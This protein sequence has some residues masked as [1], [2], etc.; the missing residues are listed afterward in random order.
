MFVTRE[1]LIKRLAEKSG[2][3][4]KD[5]KEVFNA[6]DDVV[7]EVFDEVTDDEELLLQL[8]EGIRIG[9]KVVPERARKNPRDQSDII[10]PAQVK[11]FTKFSRCFKEKI[12]VQYEDRKDG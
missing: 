11:P 6:L 8:V 4:M 1:Q 12:Q 2:Y 9:C 5:I 7:V 3:Y 10:C